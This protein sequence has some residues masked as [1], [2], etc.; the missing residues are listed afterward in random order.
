[1]TESKSVGPEP[2]F[3]AFVA[4]DWADREHAW[5]LEA[6]G[7]RRERGRLE[8]TPEAVEAWA[9]GLAERFGGRPVAVALEQ[10]RGALVC[11]LQ[12]FAH[13]VLYPIHP[14]TASKFRAALFPSGH[15][16]D[17]EDADLLLDFL[18]QQ[19]G[20]LRALRP[21]TEATRKLQALVE[22]RRQLV[23]TRTAHTNSITDLLKVYFPQALRW[24]ED[25]ASPLA[26]AA[27]QRWPTLRQLQ[28]E[29]PGQ[30]RRFFRRHHCSPTRIEERLEGI[31]KAHPA[32][33]DPAIVE[34]GVLMV[35]ALL[36]VVA[37][38]RE[39]IAGLDREIE[40]VF[41][42]HAD[43]PLFASLPG[44][45][46][47]LA[48]RLLA[49]LGS[50][51][52]RFGSA[53]EVLCYSGI[54]PVMARSGKTQ[55]WIHFRWACPKFLRQSFHEFAEC[56]IPHCE[57]ARD[58]YRQQR[59]KQKKHHAAVRALA[60]KWIRILFRCW[61]NHQPY[62]EELY[63]AARQK[64]A[65][66]LPAPAPVSAP[67]PAYGAACEKTVDSGLKKIDEVVN[68]LLARA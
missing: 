63:V 46:A 48:P 67:L 56:S 11:W 66:P 38:V 51:R 34:P 33:E 37:A 17:P 30:V 36:K 8:Q 4:L 3:A 45:G 61:Q 49:A 31:G 60:F 1:M 47:A 32:V 19:R 27:L 54:A 58:F 22:K 50:R 59:A 25:L 57:S 18:M 2:E 44:A 35:G 65:V 23:D 14:T 24:F 16:D 42:G 55:L 15:K 6:P 7:T 43:A 5:A 40:K 28:A 29:D 10:S 68:I 64:R 52:D 13:L 53:E 12:K 26:A 41:A 9:A 62:H 39:G 21:D 20:R